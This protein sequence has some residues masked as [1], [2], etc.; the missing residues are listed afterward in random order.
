MA[1]D[2]KVYQNRLDK[3]LARFGSYDDGKA[4]ERVADRIFD[5]F[6]SPTKY[7]KA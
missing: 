1:F 3:W 4:S 6:A 5:V 7:G 2:D